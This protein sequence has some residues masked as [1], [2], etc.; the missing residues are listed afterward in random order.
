MDYY[1]SVLKYPYWKK[2]LAA[3]MLALFVLNLQSTPAA[4]KKVKAKVILYVPHDNRPISDKQT[5][6]VA[7]KAGVVV[8][9][10]PEQLLGNRTAPGDPDGLYQWVMDN[11][12]DADAAVISSDAFLYGSLVTSRKHDIDRNTVLKRTDHFAS[13]HKSYPNLPIY[14]FSSIM[15]TPKNA[16]A[17]GTEEP[18]YYQTYGDSIFQYTALLDKDISQGL[19]NNEEKQM[20]QLRQNIPRNVMDDWMS[21]RR[22]NFDANK[23]LI[24]LTRN[25]II[26]Y[27]VVGCD[28]NAPLSQTHNERVMLSNVS[29]GLS[30]DKFLIAPGVDEMGLLLIT[31]AINKIYNSAPFVAIAYADGYGGATIPSYS[32][33]P[34]DNSVR[35]EI[36]LVGGRP[37]S[38]VKGSSMILLV[39]TNVS[40]TTYEASEDVNSTYPRANTKSFINMVENYLNAKIPV[41]IGDIAFSNGA[42]NALMDTLLKKD[43]LFR[44]NSYAGWNTATN[45]TGW[46]V[47]QGLLSLRMSPENKNQLLVTRYVDDWVY[48]A[49]VRQTIARML[50]IFPGRGTKLSLSDKTEPAQTDAE[51]MIQIF[52]EKH[53]PFL[54][55][56][57]VKIDFPWDRLFESDIQ[58]SQNPDE[59]TKRFFKSYK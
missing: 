24:E 28:D 22:K 38:S 46:A 26:S 57:S 6:A 43:L 13:I 39:N 15:R 49:N 53:L 9:V 25:N 5:A 10:P 18:S 50:N 58:I 20:L 37:T 8:K 36:S 16:A 41:A 14:V 55:I 7:E 33:E 17:S 34:I 54:G 12:R 44:L 21:R 59:F 40:G 1:L 31:R 2:I 23:S 4:A 51:E 48:Q 11:A 3:V 19:T 29:Q 27:L 42:D 30:S 35:S 32:D 56:N 47:A 52:L 45:S